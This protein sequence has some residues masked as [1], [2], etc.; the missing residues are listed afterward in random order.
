[1]GALSTISQSQTDLS[2]A[3]SNGLQD[4][5]TGNLADWRRQCIKKSA[6]DNAIT[7]ACQGRTV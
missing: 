2:I 3:E 5:F 6:L 4:R 1:M 7:H